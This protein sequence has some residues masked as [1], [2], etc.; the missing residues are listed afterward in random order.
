M[1]DMTAAAPDFAAAHA[2]LALSLELQAFYGVVAPA[3]VADRARQLAERAYALDP[4]SAEA[5][6]AMG[7]LR[8]IFDFDLAG[9]ERFYTLAVAANPSYDIARLGLGDCLLFR[10]DFDAALREIYAA[11]RV[12]PVRSRPAAERRRLP[13]LCRPLRGGNCATAA[14]AR[15]RPALLA[16]SLPACRSSRCDG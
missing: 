9:S 13:H 3:T 10:H 14:H 8:M 6:T 2:G 11:V 5:L 7:A 12:E 4:A 16:R 15:H 1:R